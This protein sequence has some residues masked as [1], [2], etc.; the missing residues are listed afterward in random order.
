MQAISCPRCQHWQPARFT[1]PGEPYQCPVCGQ[2]F[3]APLGMQP[4][5]IILPPE[6]IAPAPVQAPT[7]RVAASVGRSYLHAAAIGAG[8]LSAAVVGFAMLLI[9]A[10]AENAKAAKTPELASEA[11][12]AASRAARD[13]GFS[14]IASVF[15]YSWDYPIVVVE[16]TARKGDGLHEIA[17]GMRHA[18]FGEESHFEIM[19]I[20]VD[21]VETYRRP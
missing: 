10:R 12:R 2:L 3:H 7:P 9:W 15:K 5:A 19:I 8:L 14:E 1:A 6:V 16:L 13:Q 17:V 4:N 18:Q 21:G 11:G 20:E